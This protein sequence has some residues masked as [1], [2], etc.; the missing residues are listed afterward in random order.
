[1]RKINVFAI[2]FLFIVLLSGLF[3][4]VAFAAL[5]N[6]KAYSF[7]EVLTLFGL[8]VPKND[9]GILDG[10][11]NSPRTN[12]ALTAPT[13]VTKNLF[14]S[15]SGTGSGTVVSSPAGINC[16]ADCKEAFPYQTSVTLV[17]KPA[18]GSEF[19]HWEFGYWFFWDGVSR[20]GGGA[21]CSAANP[22]CVVS[23]NADKSATAVF[24]K[25][26]VSTCTDSDGGLNYEKAGT[27]YG[28][29]ADGAQYQ[30]ND[31]CSDNNTTQLFEGSCKGDFPNDLQRYECPYGCSEG[32]CNPAPTAEP[33]PTR[34]V[35]T[36]NL[37]ISKSGDG[38]GTVV[39]EPAGINC[40]ADCTEAFTYYSRVTLTARAAADSDFAG[41][42]GCDPLTNL[43]SSC[44]ISMNIDRSV[45]A[46]FKKPYAPP[47]LEPEPEPV[48]AQTTSV[49]CE[50]QNYKM[51]FIL[52]ENSS[53]PATQE[54]I[55][56]IN[57]LKQKTSETFAWATRN[58]A[59]MDTN[60]PLVILNL[61]NNPLEI[62]VIK[63]FYKSNPDNFQ[64]IT[65]FN[66][67]GISTQFSGIQHYVPVR[68]NIEGIGIPIIDRT[69]DYG[70]DGR[71]LGVNW[72][73]TIDMYEVDDDF[74]L[75][76]GV[77]GI[78]HET[79]HRWGARIDFID[80]NGQE[81]NSLRNPYNIVHWD[82]K[83]ETGYDLLNGYSWDDNGDG[84][85]TA[86]T[87]TDWRKDYSNL[88]LYLMG[89][90]SK[91]EAGPI[92][93]I[94][95]D[96]DNADIQ[97]GTT[98]SG[99]VKIISIQQIIDTE[100]ERVCLAESVSEPTPTPT[101]EPT[102]TEDQQLI[103]NLRNQISEDQQLIE[104]LRNQLS[105][106]LK[107]ISVLQAQF[108]KKLAEPQ[109]LPETAPVGEFSYTW[110]RDL[111]YGL[112]NDPDVTALQKA[113]T[114]EGVYSGSITGDFFELTRQ[115]VI[116]FQKKHNFWPIPDTGYLGL[117]TRKVLNNFYSEP[118]PTPD[119]LAC[120]TRFK[121]AF[122]YLFEN[123][124]DLQKNIQRLEKS[125]K[126]S[127]EMFNDAG[128]G[129]ISLDLSYPLVEIEITDQNR[130]K[131]LFSD[132]FDI[133]P[134][135]NKPRVSPKADEILKE[136]YKNNPDNFDFITV[137]TNFR[138]LGGAN[139]YFMLKNTIKGIGKPIFDNS[140]SYGSSGKL[141][142]WNYLG[143]LNLIFTDEFPEERSHY[144]T[145]ST[146]LNETEHQWGVYIGD[147]DGSGNNLI[148][149]IKF[150]AHWYPGLD[151][152]Y[153]PEGGG[154]WKDN[155][156]G[157]FTLKPPS[158]WWG[159]KGVENS[160]PK[161]IYSDLTLYLI[162]AIEAEKVDPILWV[163][164]SGVLLP[165]TTITSESKN[166]TIQDII[167]KEGERICNI[168]SLGV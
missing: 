79:S 167:D 124:P 72:M 102:V 23:I 128:R 56:K 162:G 8:H 111:Y 7:K 41:W 119:K 19:D 161:E 159:G 40:G 38:N 2:S 82:K 142:G 3:S 58:L 76:L 90:M 132:P 9:Y 133:N 164:Y 118:T 11:W 60:Y 27:I 113:L 109:I 37:I 104:S 20:V 70:S 163:N 22:S 25:A 122:L 28:S 35:A 89:L 85:F 81:S 112:T 78:V 39:S 47:K 52:V 5:P 4:S 131:L 156:D 13:G 14:I 116:K 137:F 12:L 135:T 54:D 146:L 63:E 15:K 77:N 55:N 123:D 26:A 29:R 53:N 160:I 74:S 97:P 130:D 62:E 32:A 158:Y 45:T 110:N 138:L 71:L 165:G 150:G 105:K 49:D 106:L 126:I 10:E 18:S 114:I 145:G 139:G 59:S 30:Y 88:D 93:L 36:K 121:M 98:I 17:A 155:G 107:L 51:A 103:K 67:Y 6:F 157:T 80:E 151:T 84:T 149:Q 46:I 33:T 57:T 48:L 152:N 68:N 108:I 21:D 147:I 148:L 66:T 117:Y 127:E 129:F 120:Q 75:T 31:F 115:G 86:K 87:I 43:S 140:A 65:I 92:Q 42:S 168:E 144:M 143:N 134:V 136:F 94:V 64:F 50:Y 96:A 141:L 34:T 100:G 73:K 61:E 99:T 95:S 125:K 154:D 44:V 1:M 16:G 24:K 166:I 91:E 101:P 153:D 69:N 83:L